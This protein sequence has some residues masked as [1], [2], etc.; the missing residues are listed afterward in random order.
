MLNRLKATQVHIIIDAPKV[1]FKASP[2]RCSDW[3]NRMNPVCSP[4]LEIDRAQIERLRAPQMKLL[5]LL[6]RD[7]PNLT[8]WDPLPLLCPTPTCSAFDDNGKPLFFDSNHLSGHGNRVLTPSF[9][10]VLLT[11]WESSQ[12][13]QH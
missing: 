3:F 11:I 1:L 13:E 6:E 4:G 5:E 12:R 2:N 8:V 10:Q 7:N 9:T